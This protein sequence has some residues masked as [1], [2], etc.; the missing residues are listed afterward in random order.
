[1]NLR[2]LVFDLIRLFKPNFISSFKIQ[3]LMNVQW[4]HTSVIQMQLAITISAHTTACV[5]LDT[6]AMAHSVKVCF[7]V[8][9]F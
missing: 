1:M 9:N 8:L 3:I 6:L 5:T 7:R 2:V 4:E